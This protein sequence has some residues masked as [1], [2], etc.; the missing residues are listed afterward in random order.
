M[1]SKR[2]IGTSIV[3]IIM[4]VAAIFA[5]ASCE[6]E[7]LPINGTFIVDGENYETKDII[8]GDASTFPENPAKD[9]YTFAG[10]YFDDGVWERPFTVET[11]LADV[12]SEKP[13]VYA[14]F[15]IKEF[16]ISFANAE[17]AE[18]SN[19]VSYTINSEKIVLADA[20]KAGYKFLGWYNGEEKVTEIDP[21]ECKDI[22]LSAKWELITYSIRYINIDG[23]SNANT[24]TY[25]VESPAIT[26]NSAYKSGVSFDGWYMGDTKVTSIPAGTVGD[27]TLTAHWRVSTLN[28]TYAGIPY[29]CVNNNSTTFTNGYGLTLQKPFMPGRIF[30]GWYYNGEK[31]DAIPASVTTDVTVKAKWVVNFTGLLVLENSQI[32]MVDAVVIIDGANLH[33]QTT[34]EENGTFAFNKIPVGAYTLTFLCDGY[35]PQ[36]AYINVSSH[37]YEAFEIEVP[38]APVPPVTDTTPVPD[39][40]AEPGEPTNLVG[41][42]Y[43]ADSD[44]TI[45][46]NAVLADATVSIANQAILAEPLVTLSDANGDYI[47]PDIAPGVY[48]LTVSKEGFITATQYV[49]VHTGNTVMQNMALEVFQEGV[50]GVTTGN[51]SGT[52]IDAAQS[53]HVTI[54]GLTLEVRVG[55]NNTTGIIVYSTETDSNGYYEIIDLEAGNYTV[56]IVDNRELADESE[57]YA[58]AHFNIKIMA[59]ETISN[60]QGSVFSGEV[61]VTDMTIV[62]EWGATPTDLDSHLTGPNGNGGRYHVYY[63]HMNDSGAS[64]DR[65]DTTSYG[66]ETITVDVSEIGIYR[67]S[68][69]DFSNSGSSSSMAMANSGAT[70]KVY[71]GGQLA[72]TY[73]APNAGGSLWVVFEYNSETGVITPINYVT[74]SGSTGSD[75]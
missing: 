41:R 58:V 52:V 48:L 63:S 25:T 42:I 51:A 30:A 44:T 53:G 21:A 27:I 32:P 67:Y 74:S 37:Y 14:K 59:G 71:L 23:A 47:F 64:L 54:A 22:T 31:I 20:E 7:N 61:T 9:G 16:D 8:L 15:D 73:Y 11:V 6:E 46:N 26:L 2:R 1:A 4:L 68:I 40:P 28:V 24:T 5:F 60:Q 12:L 72:A 43:E 34:T 35:D 39:A 66:P 33:L 70:I 36:E 50:G 69:H 19:P 3:L 38:M 45:S 56:L 75:Y 65:D 49:T 29:G 57:R 10:W 13:V 55:L 17:G 62:L 18:N